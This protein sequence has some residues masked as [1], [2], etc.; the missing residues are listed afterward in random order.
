MLTQ[1]IPYV[2]LWL[3]IYIISLY[4]VA[5]L[6]KILYKYIL[7]KIWGRIIDFLT[8]TKGAKDAS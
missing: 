3:I 5:T 1:S 7:E 4:A 6:I 2:I 8:G